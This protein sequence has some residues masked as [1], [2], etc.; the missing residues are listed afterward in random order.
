MA[1]PFTMLESDHRQVEQLL[2]SLA[3]AEEERER[4]ELVGQLVAALSLHM[5]FEE[6]YV[7]PLTRQLIGE[8][9]AQEANIEHQLAREGLDKLESLLSAPG[10]GAA[11]A[12][13]EAGIGH[14]VEEEEGEMFPQ[15]RDEVDVDE[16][17]ELA[18]QLV[19]AKRDAGLLPVTL[20]KASKDDLLL[21]S[22]ALGLAAKRSMNKNQLT[23]LIESSGA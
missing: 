3:D 21:I 11:V 1:D 9:E 2:A 15:L 19:L 13:V 4:A 18:R 10:F 22:E 5:Q 8:E 6:R 17:A 14:H 7:Y 12:M 20:E 23:L 16:Q